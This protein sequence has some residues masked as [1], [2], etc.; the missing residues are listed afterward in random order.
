[1][2]R[3]ATAL[4]LLLP[5]TMVAQTLPAVEWQRNLGG[6]QA[7]IANSIAQTADGGYIICGTTESNDGDITNFQGVQDIWVVK[8]DESGSI[9]WQRSLGGSSYDFGGQA[10]PL[11]NGGYLVTGGTRSNN[12][13]VSGNHGMHDVW[14]ARLNAVGDLLWQQCYGGSMNDWG[15][16]ILP[17][18]DGGF[19]IVGSSGSSNG[20][21]TSNAGLM[22]Y[23]VLKVNEV[24]AIQWQRSLGGSMGEDA[25]FISHAQEGGYIV[26]GSTESNNGDMVGAH[27]ALDQWIIK[28]NSEGHLEW[29]RP[30]GGSGVE[31]GY[32]IVEVYGGSY[33]SVGSSDSQDG[34]ITEPKGGEDLW[35]ILLS[36]SGE[37]LFDRSYGGTGSD[38]GL[39]ALAMEDGGIIYCG[40]SNSSDGD[41]NVNQG[42]T[43]G[44]LFRTNDQGDIVWNLVMGGSNNDSFRAI[45]PTSDGGYIVVGTS[46]SND[47]DLP[48]NNGASDIWVVKLGPD[49]VNVRE[50]NN[51]AIIQVFPNPVTDHIRVELPPGMHNAFWHLHDAQGRV[52]ASGQAHGMTQQISVQHLT[53]GAY[54]LVVEA[55]GGRQ[56][57]VVVKK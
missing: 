5:F 33:L 30:C 20:D 31:F 14:L 57:V 19:V 23:W 1:M 29:Q 24:G 37:A 50:R 6:S 42:G 35:S 16:G 41:L 12:G 4:L 46:S 26:T 40:L 55:Q 18:P 3:Y 43:D 27:G 39:D 44:W 56:S 13:H 7:D 52:V 51:E 54:T 22:D 11:P 38:I 25:F 48:G 36:A 32:A 2:F 45:S 53:S 15:R 34:D 17:T 9:Q 8:L 47:G 49:V 10:I 28:L 21:V